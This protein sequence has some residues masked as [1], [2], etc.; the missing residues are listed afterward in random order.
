MCWLCSPAHEQRHQDSL[1][2]APHLRVVVALPGELSHGAV[3]QPDVDASH[4]VLHALLLGEAA[5]QGVEDRRTG[6]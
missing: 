1:R 5:L 4:G 3:A 2:G 6:A